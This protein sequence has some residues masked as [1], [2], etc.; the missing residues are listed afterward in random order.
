MET[1]ALSLRASCFQ[2]LPAAGPSTLL[3][4][5]FLAASGAWA[6][7]A[8]L[9]ALAQPEGQRCRVSQAALLGKSVGR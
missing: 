8:T 9:L 3:Q 4:G 1:L 6:L 5:L 7:L 2:W